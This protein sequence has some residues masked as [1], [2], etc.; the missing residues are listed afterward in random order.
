M[1]VEYQANWTFSKNKTQNQDNPTVTQQSHILNL[2]IYP[3]KNQYFH[4]KILVDNFV[5]IH[6]KH[7]HF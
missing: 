2:N 6:C 3:A 7:N 5:Q 4:W 1:N